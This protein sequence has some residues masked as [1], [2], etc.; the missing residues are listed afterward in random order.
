MSLKQR[1]RRWA[2][3]NATVCCKSIFRLKRGFFPD[4]VKSKGKNGFYYVGDRE[5]YIGLGFNTNSIPQ[6]EAPKSLRDL[7]NPKW[8]GK[9]SIVTSSTG[10]RLDRQCYRRDGA[11]VRR[12][13]C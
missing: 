5:T 3:S 12:Q 2:Y 6:T 4:D 7:L 13:A 1:P 11:R 10:T 8:K 9:M